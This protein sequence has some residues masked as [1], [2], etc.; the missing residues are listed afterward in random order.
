MEMPVQAKIFS[1]SINYICGE[2]KVFQDKIKFK[3]YLSTKL[4]LQGITE[5]KVHHE[6][7]N[8]TQEKPR[9]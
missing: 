7:E 6:K 3:Q 1:K 4:A 2:L 5:G 8:Y 9:N